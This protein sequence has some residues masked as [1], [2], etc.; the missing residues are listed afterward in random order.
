MPEAKITQ[1]WPIPLFQ[2]N[3]LI[4]ED[5]KQKFY[6]EKYERMPSENGAF[7]E[8][9]YILHSP[10]YAE[11]KENILINVSVYTKKFLNI[12]D[13]V[14][15]YLQNSWG[16]KH[17]PGD[18]GQPHTHGNSLLSGVYYLKTDNESGNIQFNQ[19]GGYTNL[20]HQSIRVPFN[21]HDNIS[22]D[23]W[24]VT[25]EVGD[26]VLFPSH[27]SHSIK[28]NNSNII[29]YSLAFNL[30]VEGELYSPKSPID[31]LKLRNGNKNE[32][33]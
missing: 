19:P 20:F 25:P 7:T 5:T 1:L 2:S 17:M 32:Q 9:K 29:R 10:E 21:E 26:M 8:N 23:T 12:S 27:L 31:Y 24:N 30:H 6:N 16:V 22:C 11:I 3:F 18:W 33:S 15:F 28:T 13:R 14:K 4:S